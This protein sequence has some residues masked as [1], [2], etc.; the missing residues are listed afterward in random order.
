MF[1][2][3]NQYNMNN[4]LLVVLDNNKTKKIGLDHVV[5]VDGKESTVNSLALKTNFEDGD[6]FFE[7]A[8]Q[9][10]DRFKGTVGVKYIEIKA[11]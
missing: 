2:L 6:D 4:T 1:Y 3:K 7:S 8:S 10:L 9:A 5:M 11:L